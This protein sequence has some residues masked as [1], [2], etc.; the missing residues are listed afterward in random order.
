MHFRQLICLIQCLKAWEIVIKENI[1]ALELDLRPDCIKSFEK[2][3]KFWTF[4]NL[5]WK[6]SPI[7]ILMSTNLLQIQNLCTLQSKVFQSWIILCCFNKFT[8]SSNF[9]WC[10]FT[11]LSCFPNNEQLSLHLI[12]SLETQ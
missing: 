12:H 3:S 5:K 9:L 6:D 8:F 10:I 2:D 7:K 4:W 11:L 1:I